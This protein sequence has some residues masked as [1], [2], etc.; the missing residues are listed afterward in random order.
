MSRFRALALVPAL[1]LAVGLVG[2]SSEPDPAPPAAATTTSA[3]VDRTADVKRAAGD[4]VTRAVESEP[5]RF[6]VETTI[7][8]PRGG[9]G[10]D[11]A[12]AALAICAAVVD[13]GATYVRVLE[14]DGTTFVI[15]A[16]AQYGEECAES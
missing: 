3:E 12:K 13:L 7:V 11:E 8:D 16:P 1:A 9:E 15:Y 2:C 10:S 4:A 14:K 6:E 5:G